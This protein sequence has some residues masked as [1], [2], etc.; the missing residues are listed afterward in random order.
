L[1]VPKK[2]VKKH[3]DMK[4]QKSV[5]SLCLTL[6]LFISSSKAQN[7][8][9]ESG[10][11]IGEECPAFDPKH[12]TGPDKGKSSC[13]MCRYGYQQGVLIWMN[14]DDWDNMGTLTSA[15]ESEIKKKGLKRIRVFLMYMNP[16]NKNHQEIE[17]LLTK[18]SEKHHLDKVALT[19][20]PNPTDPET[21]GLYNINAD[22]KI[23]NTVIVYKNRGVFDKVVN[24]KSDAASIQKLIASIEKAE[25]TKKF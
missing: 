3:F 23:R 16:E 5:L 8:A 4:L 18:F 24:F 6:L 9:L 10:P 2:P 11:S 21:A 7:G 20:I 19:Y 1:Q 15:L 13:P 12:V 14:S 25:Q 22:T 17:S